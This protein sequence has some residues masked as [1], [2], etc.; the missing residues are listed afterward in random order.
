MKTSG[1]SILLRVEQF[2]FFKIRN[3]AMEWRP[4]KNMIKEGFCKLASIKSVKTD[5]ACIFFFFLSL[6]QIWSK[7]FF[8]NTGALFNS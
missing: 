6:F 1:E 5:C 3:Y 4:E 2:F 7:H 8:N